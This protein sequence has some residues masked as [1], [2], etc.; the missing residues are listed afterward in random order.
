MQRGALGT[1]LRRALQRGTPEYGDA[2]NVGATT[3]YDQP[4]MPVGPGT[5]RLRTSKRCGTPIEAALTMFRDLT[6]QLSVNGWWR[7][8]PLGD[9]PS[10]RPTKLEWS[11]T[12]GRPRGSSLTSEVGGSDSLSTYRIDRFLAD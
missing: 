3:V 9:E 12:L 6:D 10:A 7:G 8:W 1:R 11:I 2:Q 5:N 4:S